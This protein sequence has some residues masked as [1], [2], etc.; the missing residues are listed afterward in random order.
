MR[1]QSD[2]HLERAIDETR[3][4]ISERPAPDLTAHI[5]RRIDELG[6]TPARPSALRRILDGF[7]APRRVE[8]HWRPAYAV[9]G[10][11]AVILLIALLPY[12]GRTTATPPASLAAAGTGDPRLFVQF[13]LDAP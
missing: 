1:D 11:A 8:L 12:G 3:A 13:H 2:R 5:M 9:I 7:W 10:A 6:A 4:F